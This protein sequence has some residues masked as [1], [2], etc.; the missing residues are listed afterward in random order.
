MKE[1]AVLFAPYVPALQT[2]LWC[3]LILCLLLA[4]RQSIS[5]LLRAFVDRLKAGGTLRFGKMEIGEVPFVTKT[6]DLLEDVELFGNP[7]HFQLLFK[8]KGGTWS[9]STK[10]METPKGCIVQVTNE[11]LQADGSWRAAEAVTFVPNVAV[12]MEPDGSGRRLAALLR[13][14]AAGES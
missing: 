12:I 14:S 7:D 6:K 1:A 8:A 2:L 5:L 4:F 13:D 11:H 9:N 3:L 10:A